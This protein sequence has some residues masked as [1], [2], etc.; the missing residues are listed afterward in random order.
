MSDSPAYFRWS[1]QF[2]A[3]INEAWARRCDRQFVVGKTYRLEELSERS[4]I[5]HAHEFAWLRSAWLTLPEHLSDRFPTPEALRKAALIESGF[6]EERQIDAGSKAAALRVAAYI[7]SEDEFSYIVVRGP[8]V[9]IR[10]AKSQSRRAM[11]KKDFQASKTAIMEVIAAMIGVR[12]EDLS[13]E[14]A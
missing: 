8:W 9:V 11:D 6:Y 3:P 12:P 4:E 2:M 10:K 7:R 13:R 5:S 14:A 1:G